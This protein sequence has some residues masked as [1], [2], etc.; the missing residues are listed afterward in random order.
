MQSNSSDI[1]LMLELSESWM[2]SFISGR[3]CEEHGKMSTTFTVDIEGYDVI[4]DT[5]QNNPKLPEEA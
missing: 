2:P 1:S 3:H 5:I 4:Y